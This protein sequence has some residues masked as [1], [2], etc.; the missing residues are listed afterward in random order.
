MKIETIYV[1]IFFPH[2]STKENTSR[3]QKRVVHLIL[4]LSSDDICIHIQILFF[5]YLFNLID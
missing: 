3:E 5:A 4:H 2:K 1:H